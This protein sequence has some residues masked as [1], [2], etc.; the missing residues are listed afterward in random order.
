MLLPEMRLEPRSNQSVSSASV[1]TRASPAGISSPHAEHF[2]AEGWVPPEVIC[3]VGSAMY[4]LSVP[5]GKA[6][7]DTPLAG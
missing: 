3:N 1:V 7:A 6:S 5:F 2:A 4:G